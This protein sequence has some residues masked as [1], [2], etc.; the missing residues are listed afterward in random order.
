MKLSEYCKGEYTP[1]AGVA[2]Q[3]LWYFVG[4]PLVRSHLIP[5]SVVKVA[6]LRLFGATVGRGVRIKPGLRVKFPWRLR[7]GNDS[8][9]GE[10]AWID[11]QAN[12]TIGSD[13]C[14]SQQA[15]L[16]TGSHDWTSE[17]FDLITREIELENHSWVAARA[18]VAPGTR[19]GEGAVLGLAS[20]GRGELEPWSIYVGVPAEKVGDRVIEADS[21]ALADG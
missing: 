4:F 2:K 16:C 6:T 19:L 17:S 1:G 7:V 11:N 20:L 10:D 3:L 13:C 14:V 21:P 18:S 15:Y 8:W 5:F 9:L 12:V